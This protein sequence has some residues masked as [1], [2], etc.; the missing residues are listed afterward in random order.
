MLAGGLAGG[1]AAACTTPLDCIK[2]V[3]NTQQT[4][5]TV[6]NGN[7]KVLLKSTGVYRGINLILN[8]M[9]LGIFDA[10]NTIYSSRGLAGFGIGIYIEFFTKFR[11]LC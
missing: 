6:C 11:Q 2:T 5:K 8:L 1:L 4:P 9:L 3:L 7:R 10:I